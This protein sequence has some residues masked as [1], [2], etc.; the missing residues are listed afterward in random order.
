MSVIRHVLIAFLILSSSWALATPET[1]VYTLQNRTA[2]QLSQEIKTLYPSGQVQVTNDGQQLM[3]RGEPGTLDEIGQLIER[4]DVPQ[5]QLRITVRVFSGGDQSTNGAGISSDGHSVSAGAGSRTI[6]TAT[7]SE[8]SLVVQD[9][10]TAHIS[11]GRVETVPIA[12][13]GGENPAAILKS[14]DI[15][16]GFLVRPQVISERQIQLDIVSF[17]DHPERDSNGYETAAV[18][19]IR[20]VEP[21][22]WVTLGASKKNAQQHRKG[23]TYQ[24]GGRQQDQKTYQ[25]RVDLM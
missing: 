2:G 17:N 20:R 8:Q 5:H 4:L 15:K 1:R 18:M 21:G 16:H 7:H 12:I 11:A 19:T 10:A 6:T 23:I 13:Q 3:V 24:A 22:H 9:G 25:V 14:V